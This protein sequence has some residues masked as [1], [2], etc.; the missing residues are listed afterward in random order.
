ML[1]GYHMLAQTSKRKE[2]QNGSIPCILTGCDEPRSSD[3]NQ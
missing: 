1:L 2:I 3:L